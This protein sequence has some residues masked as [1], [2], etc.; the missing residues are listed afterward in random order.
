M[1][2]RQLFVK[3]R[4]SGL[5]SGSS[6]RSIRLA[7]VEPVYA[8]KHENEIVD[9]VCCLQQLLLA[10]RLVYLRLLRLT[11]RATPSARASAVQIGARAA[12]LLA[13]TSAPSSTVKHLQHRIQ[14]SQLQLPKG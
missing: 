6:C 2:G 13:G 5:G 9:A 4:A 12:Q 1:C 11:A 10:A 7:L 8:V 3:L 14:C